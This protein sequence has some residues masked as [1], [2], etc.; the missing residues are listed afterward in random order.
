MPTI[1][2]VWEQAL[3]IN[4]NLATLHNDQIDLKNC[5]ALTNQRL[6]ALD[7]GNQETNDWLEDIRKVLGEGFAAMA[8]G[9]S[10]VHVRQ[11]LANRLLLHL[12]EQQRTVICLLEKIADNT[13]AL[14]NQSHRQTALQTTLNTGMQAVAHMYASTNPD[15]ALQH[16]RAQEQQHKL[17]K[18]CPP[19]PLE[20]PCRPA[21]CPQPPAIDL[22]APK[23]FE[24]Y[25]AEPPKVKR[26]PRQES[27]K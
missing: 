9:I 2:E 25:R 24:G 18:C 12:S 19:R 13:C 21:P 11:D 3:L 27:L 16:Q 7:A 10:G 23:E 6:A 22:P 17:E 4:A 15:A 14:V 20:D 1:N 8:S 26:R 5:C